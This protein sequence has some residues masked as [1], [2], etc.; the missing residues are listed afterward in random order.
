M[1][2]ILTTTLYLLFIIIVLPASGQ[3]KKFSA[4]Y[5]ITQTNDSIACEFEPYNWKNNL[6]Q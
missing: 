1:K 4:G 3:K 2:I 6:H 5:I